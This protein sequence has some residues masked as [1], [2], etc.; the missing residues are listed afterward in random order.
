MDYNARGMF[1][2][3]D[4]T[5]SSPALDSALDW[6]AKPPAQDPL[7][8]LVPL[9]NHLS[10]FED[11]GVAPLQLLRILELFQ[12]RVNAI[13]AALKP[14]LQETSLPVDTRLRTI[15]QGLLDVHG[16]IAAAYVKVMREADRDRMQGMHRNPT[17]LSALALGNLLQQLEVSLLIS[18]LAPPEMWRNAQVIHN[19]TMD[20]IPHDST[21]PAGATAAQR[22]FKTMLALAAAQPESFTPA[23]LAF[24]LGYLREFGTEVVMQNEAPIKARDTWYWINDGLDQP[25]CATV[26]RPPPS[27]GR[28][29][30][31]SC[32]ELGRTALEHTEQLG[33][34]EEPVALGLDTRGTE[35]ALRHAL[36]RAAGRW[37]SPPKRHTQR[38]GSSARV[39]VC[40]DMAAL[41][42]HR[43]GDHQ[44]IANAIG[45]TAT[46]WMMLNESPGGLAIMHVSG[47]TRGL[48]AGSALAV[49][50]AADQPWG[51][52]VVRWAR[53]DNPEHLELGLEIVAPSAQA[54]RI[55][56][57][58]AAGTDASAEAFLLPPLTATQ[59]GEA[60][61]CLPGVHE[62]GPFTLVSENSG[63]IQLTECMP[64]TLLLQTGRMELF[65]F[66]RDF[67]PAG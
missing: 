30:C 38:R 16:A 13:N 49:K 47:N 10:A 55:I 40:T 25:P 42:Q 18:S 14:L 33:A 58:G 23:E 22:H 3:I 5:V 36:R 52:C 65:E 53:S 48:I 20:V 67:S 34:G 66:S 12:P 45:V 19:W 6:L 1:Q 32:R 43:H 35:P 41:W 62:T 4:P 64:T 15:S 7:R 60:L 21:M 59:R 2:T 39:Q 46:D 26:R 24:L 44:P 37:L 8:D 50:P 56:R 27:G 61:L 9:R 57:Q 11:M 63:R 31:F 29:I 17:S 54:V 51:L 28:T